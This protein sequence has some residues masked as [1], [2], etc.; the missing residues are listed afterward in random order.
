MSASPAA[1]AQTFLAFDFGLKRVG[2]ATGN[3]LLGQ[4]RPLRTIAAEGDARFAAIGK[5]IE[6][7]APDAL[8]VGVPFHPDGAEHENTVRARRFG[9]QLHGR[10]RLPVIEVDE[11]YST[12]EAQSAQA[13]DLD[14]ASAAI[15]LQQHLDAL[16]SAAVIPDEPS[17]A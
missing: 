4:A 13:R 9:R 2:V 14:A 1:R 16:A 7:W 15:I 17:E 5:L 8:V 10:F 12:T 6:E 3:T 11:R